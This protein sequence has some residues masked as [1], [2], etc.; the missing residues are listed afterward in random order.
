MDKKNNITILRQLADGIDPYTGEKLPEQ[1]PYQYPQTVRALF[2]AILAL[3]RMKESASNENPQLA[4]AGKPWESAEDDQLKEEI[5]GGISI[6]K[7][8]QTHQRTIGA[9]ESRLVRLGKLTKANYLPPV[10]PN[11]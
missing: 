7:L 9:I 8:A 10:R 1:S 5:D 11:K 3:E 2:H 4:K 6:K